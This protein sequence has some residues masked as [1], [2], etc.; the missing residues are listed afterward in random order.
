MQ[1]RSII[2]SNENIYFFQENS[3]SNSDSKLLTQCNQLQSLD[4]FITAIERV[5]NT[6][7]TQISRQLILHSLSSLSLK[8]SEFMFGL[9]NL[10]K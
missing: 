8:Q 10:G 1:I 7:K 6:V 3:F 9:A 4:D 2:L 5:T